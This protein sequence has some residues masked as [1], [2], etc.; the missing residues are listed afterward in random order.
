MIAMADKPL[1]KSP[2]RAITRRRPAVTRILDET[3]RPFPTRAAVAASTGSRAGYDAAATNRFNENHFLDADGSDA[4]TLVRQSLVTLRNR[5]RYEVRNN[6]YAKGMVKTYADDVVGSGPR[7]QILPAIPGDTAAEEAANTIEDAFGRWAETCG[8]NNESLGEI[9]HLAIKQLH[10]SGECFIVFRD[11]GDK[12]EIDGVTLRVQ[13]VEGDR[14]ATPAD[15]ISLT[16]A[17]GKAHAKVRDGIEFDEDG[18]PV[19]YFISKKHPGDGLGGWLSATDYDRVEARFVIHLFDTDRPGQTRGVP[20]LTPSLTL[21]SQ[22]R[23]YTLATLTAAEIAA[24]LAGVIET[25]NPNVDPEEVEAFDAVEIE[26]G[27]L[28]TLPLN[29]TAK[30]MKAE[31][32][33]SQY[34][35]FKHEVLKEIGRPNSMAY[36][37]VAGDSSEYNYA[38]GRM[39]NQKYYKGVFV[40]QDWLGRKGGD[41]ILNEWL[42]ERSLRLN[43][44]SAPVR[45]TWFWDG[46]EHVDPTKESKAQDTRLKNGTTTLA[47]E[48]AHQGLDWRRET[49]QRYV[50]AQFA[51]QLEEK[52]GPLPARK[53]PAPVAVTD[54]EDDEDEKE[55]D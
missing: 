31:Q 3:G 5:A 22:L 8:M 34:A 55:K 53:A 37:V 51:Q 46:S 26:R 28:M 25:T 15:K 38:S 48:Y 6:G 2:Q 42:R 43:A 50:E 21:F 45:H 33:T 18:R 27:H 30:Q 35:P 40:R 17:T 47:R 54:D 49:E 13:I 10:D 20:W 44:P 12:A 29:S 32:P 16:L 4:A 7:L 14:V 1:T 19:A 39:D 11:G 41:R 9:F 24:D 23:R 52:Y 36:N